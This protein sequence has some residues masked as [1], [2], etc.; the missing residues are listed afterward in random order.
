MFGLPGGAILPVYD[1]LIDSSIR[2]ILVRHEQ[3]AGHMASRLR[4]RD[5]AARCR[6]GHERS[7]GDQHRHAA[8]RRVHG[9]DPDRRDHRSGRVLGD[10]HRRV[11]GGRHGRHHDA[12]HEAQLVDQ[13]REGHPPRRPRG[14]PRRDDGPARSGAHRPA[15]GRRQPADGVVLARE[16]R[17]AR[18]Q[19]ER[20]GSPAP[21]QGRG[22]ADQ[23]GAPA[24]DLRGWRH[25]ARERD[26]PSCGRWPSSSETPPTARVRRGC[27]GSRRRPGSSRPRR[28]SRDRPKAA[29]SARFAAS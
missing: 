29:R 17:H 12:G 8:V 24:G 16:D 25:H 10:R 23:R 27:A 1:P 6:D 13:R 15:E 7:R 2:H 26:E 9:L 21:D 4:A 3:G 5:R 22:Q 19:A 28:R 20:E 11:P 18:L 14:V